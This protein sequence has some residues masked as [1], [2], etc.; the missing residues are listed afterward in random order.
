MEKYL[1]FFS[2]INSRKIS[3]DKSTIEQD[4]C[5]WY[6]SGDVILRKQYQ[7]C[8]TLRPTEIR[9]LNV[10]SSRA[11][12]NLFVLEKLVIMSVSVWSLVLLIFEGHFHVFWNELKKLGNII[13]K[14]ICFQHWNWNYGI[15]KVDLESIWNILLLPFEQSYS[16]KRILQC[17][18]HPQFNQWNIAYIVVGDK[19]CSRSHV[20]QNH[21]RSMITCT[22][23]AIKSYLL[24]NH[25]Y[26]K[27]PYVPKS[28]VLQNSIR[29]RISC[30]PLS[31]F[32]RIHKCSTISLVSKSHVFQNPIRFRIT[33]V[34]KY[35]LFQNH[36]CSEIR[37]FWNHMCSKITCVSKL[38]MFEN[39]RN[40]K[41]DIF[42]HSWSK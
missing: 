29:F 19:L 8:L 2:W 6:F 39:R 11:I 26:S 41:L 25:I 36:V 22:A 34:S 10:G 13:W 35:H 37:L 24:E 16:L 28:Q 18:L 1:E 21:M 40:P 33:C 5:S 7:I 42:D 14:S 20:F 12:K 32:F 17:C 23:C 38:H 31:H 27:I 4:Y 3:Y 30:V 9:F 15:S